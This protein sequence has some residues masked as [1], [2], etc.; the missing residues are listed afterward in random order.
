[1]NQ[2][3]TRA[4]SS[5]QALV[6]YAMLMIMIIVAA[7]VFVVIPRLARLVVSR[8]GPVMMGSR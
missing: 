8:R 2:H 4:R 1:M 6:E 7:L 5:G 3:K